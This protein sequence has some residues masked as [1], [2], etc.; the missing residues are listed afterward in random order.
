MRIVSRAAFFLALVLALD[1]AACASG[2]MPGTRA[3]E[4][5]PGMAGG[6]RDV[7]DSNDANKDSCVTW[8]IDKVKE[9]NGA[10][11]SEYNTVKVLGQVVSGMKYAIWIQETRQDGECK[12]HYVE[13]YDVPWK[14]ERELLKLEEENCPKT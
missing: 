4:S 7:T 10:E 12:E 2:A 5:Q 11:G 6:W 3:T 1:A 9:G 8:A 13:V 14:K